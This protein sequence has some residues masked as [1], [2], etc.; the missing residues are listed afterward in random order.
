MARYY[1]RV[2]DDDTG[3]VRRVYLRSSDLDAAIRE[4]TGLEAAEVGQIVDVYRDGDRYDEPAAV[5][6]DVEG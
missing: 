6:V 2:E 5:D 4:T 1:V 3:R